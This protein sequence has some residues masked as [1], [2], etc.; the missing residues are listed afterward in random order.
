MA[1]SCHLR[2][3]VYIKSLELGNLP[4]Q[5]L[6]TTTLCWMEPG[7]GA[8]QGCR[9][10][11]LK[12]ALSGCWGWIVELTLPCSLICQHGLSEP[13]GPGKLGESS[14]LLKTCLAHP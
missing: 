11:L 13:S 5:A 7:L 3:T 14:G 6:R 9:S 4:H 2:K 10:V 1:F 8:G 12:A